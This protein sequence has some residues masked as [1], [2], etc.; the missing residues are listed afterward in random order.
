MCTCSEQECQE[1]HKHHEETLRE[2][3]EEYK[4]SILCLWQAGERQHQHPSKSL[5][6]IFRHSKEKTEAHNCQELEGNCQ[7]HSKP[8]MDNVKR[9]ITLAMG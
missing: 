1:V 4:P 2:V 8:A 9:S 6:V 5:S 3:I 7:E